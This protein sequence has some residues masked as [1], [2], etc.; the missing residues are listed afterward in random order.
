VNTYPRSGEANAPK[1]PLRASREEIVQNVQTRQGLVVSD[2]SDAESTTLTIRSQKE[3][4]RAHHSERGEKRLQ[5]R[6]VEDLRLPE[7]LERRAEDS[8][9]G[10]DARRILTDPK[11]GR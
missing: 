11:E 5:G 1:I 10:E 8:M 4:D 6:P 2:R 3:D 7:E 9:D